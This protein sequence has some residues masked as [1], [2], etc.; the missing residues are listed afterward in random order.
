MQYIIK[1]LSF[2]LFFLQILFV[3]SLYANANEAFILFTIASIKGDTFYEVRMDK[4]EN[5]YVD[6]EDVL[7]NYLD[8]SDVKCN[9]ARQYCQGKLQ[10]EGI[11][12]WI[13]GVQG[14]YG[15][16]KSAGSSEKMS[17]ELFFVQ[18]GRFWL[19]YDM[20]SKWLPLEARWSLSSYHLSIIPRF[21]LRSDRERLREREIELSKISKRKRE[22]LEKTEAIKPKEIF[23]PEFKH[24]TSIRKYPRQDPGADFNYDFNVDAFRG[25]A[26]FGGVVNYDRKLSAQRPYWLYRLRDQDLFY[27][28]E[29]GDTIFQEADLVLPNLSVNNGFRLDSREIEYGEGKVLLNG[30]AAPGTKIDLYRDG[31]YLGTTVTGND[32]RY[33]F[34]DIQVSSR[35][36]LVAKIYY[37]DGS[38]EIKDIP[39]SQDNGMIIKQGDFEY[40][41]LTGETS[42]GRMNFLSL[43]YG[44]FKGVSLGLSPMFFEG[45][46]HASIKSD[47]GIRPFS[48]LS[49]MGQTLFTGRNID[50]AFRLNTTVLY[51]NFLQLEHRY[52]NEDSPNFLKNY[53]PLG[54]YWAGRHNVGW[55]RIQVINQYEQYSNIRSVS[56]DF[57]YKITRILRP[58]LSYNIFFPKDSSNYSTF[59]TGLDIITSDKSNLQIYRTW[60]KPYSRN[61]LSFILRDAFNVG[62][63]DWTLSINIPDRIK[64][65]SLYS[66]VMYRVTKNIS[67]G[68]MV[69]DKYFGFRV[70]LEGI[71]TPEPMP[72]TWREFGTGTLTG[73]VMSPSEDEEASFPL[74]DASVMVGNRTVTSNENGE[75]L[76]SGIAPYQKLM[77][78]V[79]PNTI[80][81]SMITKDEFN[82]VYFRPGTYID[83]NP[84][85]V[86]TEGID[87]NV[88]TDRELSPDA[89]ISAIKMPE[90]QLVSKGRVEGDGFF[91]IERMPPGDYELK[92]KDK[93]FLVDAKMK[94]EKEDAWLSGIEWDLDSKKIYKDSR[95]KLKAS[96]S[97][98]IIKGL[99]PKTKQHDAKS[100][101]ETTKPQKRVLSPAAKS[102]KTPEIDLENRYYKIEGMPLYIVKTPGPTRGLDGRI[103]TK[104]KIP[105]GILIDAVRTKDGVVLSSGFV[106]RDGSFVID[107]LT[108]G[109]Y[110]LVLKGVLDPPPPIIVEIEKDDDWLSGISLY[111]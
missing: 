10:P 33:V 84:E 102:S 1:K 30:R 53:R 18:D 64:E 111:W 110:K 70:N 108:S 98:Q 14:E 37:S 82:V 8:F 43:R 55:G 100:L 25:T 45:E 91:I 19:R 51:P 34:S 74:E 71:W 90:G 77:V 38:E 20:L 59:K 78:S 68:L 39:I 44:L 101:P 54:E 109:E 52:Y 85:L 72:E 73:K 96:S 12:F 66:D 27:L 81:A 5:P 93:D 61:T 31:F 40:R 67:L 89:L 42:Q 62:G 9:L 57:Y 56:S 13:E 35:S 99:M 47:I 22:L 4:N 104:N 21:K 63:W 17:S 79:N 28:M 76:V 32:G 87:G 103:I 75:F 60:M 58:F 95:P 48:E 41:V 23:R 6:V 80:D 15:D 3:G 69:V 105:N 24:R 88:I 46:D 26:L 50:R 65:S 83:W 94:L 7:L 49:F 29:I 36:R 106:E 16:S 97:P 107:K 11:L 2:F 92:F 86:T